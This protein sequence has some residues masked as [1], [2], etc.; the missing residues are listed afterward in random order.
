VTFGIPYGTGNEV[1]LMAKDVHC[2]VCGKLPPD[3]TRSAAVTV[4][5]TDYRGRPLEV[6]G[7]YFLCLGCRQ[8]VAYAE[9]AKKQA[10]KAGEA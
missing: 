10:S 6:P 7:V 4:P 2:Q 5:V 9:K 1:M 8:A 3:G